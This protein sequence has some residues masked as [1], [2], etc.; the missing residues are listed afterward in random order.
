VK[1]FTGASLFE[2]AFSNVAAGQASKGVVDQNL[3]PRDRITEMQR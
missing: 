3:M 1:R 2:G